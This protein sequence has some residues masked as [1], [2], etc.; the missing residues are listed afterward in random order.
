M[1]ISKRTY[2]LYH[3]FKLGTVHTLST[4]TESSPRTARQVV[5]DFHNMYV[6]SSYLLLTV[7]RQLSY[8]LVPVVIQFSATV[9]LLFLRVESTEQVTL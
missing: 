9:N 4:D 5:L 1:V 6:H 2:Q 8:I 3:A 7:P